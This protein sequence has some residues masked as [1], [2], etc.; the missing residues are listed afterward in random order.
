MTSPRARRGELIAIEGIDG[1]GKSTVVRGVARSLRRRGFSV[2]VRREPADPV[3]GALAQRA[4]TS[5]PWTGGIYFTLDRFA[6]RSSLERDLSRHDLVITDR[7][8]YSTLAYQGSALP[9]AERARLA[10]LQR[11]ATL[12]PDRVVLL[13]LSLAEAARRRRRR[14]GMRAPLEGDAVQ[15][16]VSREYHRLA[17]DRRWIVIDAERTVR[18]IVAETSA[19]LASRARRRPGRRPR[20]RN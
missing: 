20:R 3:L 5:D 10:R 18:E 17:R 12:E 9:N 1:A 6:A 2:A 8:F 7:S 11:G 14:A 4:A 19:R 15:A 16:R 13:D